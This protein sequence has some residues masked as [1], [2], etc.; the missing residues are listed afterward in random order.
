[1]DARL[2]LGLVGCGAI[3]AWHHDAIDRRAERTTVTATVDPD[4]ARAEALAARSGATA[5]ASLDEALA[6]DAF[7]AALVMVPHHLHDE[8]ATT[9]LDAG[10][11]L[12]LEKPVAHTVE[13]AERVLAA[14]AAADVVFQIAE[15][16]QFWP[17]V[18]E[19]QRLIAEG[20]VGDVISARSWHCAPPMGD[21][22]A[23][24]AWRLSAGSAGGGVAIDTGSHWFRPLRMWLGEVTEVLAVTGHPFAGMEGESMVRSLGRFDSGV[25]ASFDVTLTPGA[26]ALEPFFQVTGTKGELVV[27]ALGEVVLWDGS[28]GTELTGTVVSR[29]NYMHS[30]GNQIRAFEAA[31]LDGAEYPVPPEYALG[32][33]RTAHALYRSAET[34][35]WEPVW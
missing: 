10:K 30:Y 22:Y 28:P 13:S 21:F 31:V 4:R 15:N 8:V 32:E 3:A 20:A 12:L 17:E 25:V 19:V 6:T 7:D 5:F 24:G 26:A 33:L 1:M 2:H 34:R 35:Q 9:V 11:H 16:A 23:D 27:E 14:G 18:V 29:G